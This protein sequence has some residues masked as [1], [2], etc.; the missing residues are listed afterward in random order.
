MVER[1]EEKRGQVR[2]KQSVTN[3]LYFFPSRVSL[4]DEEWHVCLVKGFTATGEML[5]D[6][7]YIIRVQNDDCVLWLLSELL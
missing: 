1:G 6:T 7:D 5:S 4:T 2:R 3:F